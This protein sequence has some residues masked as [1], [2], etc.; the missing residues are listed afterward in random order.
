MIFHQYQ[1]QPTQTIKSLITER[2][3]QEYIK[4]NTAAAPSA[5]PNQRSHQQQLSQQ[6]P[7]FRVERTNDIHAKKHKQRSFQN[8]KYGQDEDHR[9]GKLDDGPL[10]FQDLQVFGGPADENVGDMTPHKDNKT[11]LSASENLSKSQYLS[12]SF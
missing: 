4:G 11:N 8:H 10:K 6:I 7:R 5:T 12:S 9:A 1:Q 2:A 3:K